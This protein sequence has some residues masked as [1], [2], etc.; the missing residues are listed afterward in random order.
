MKGGLQLEGHETFGNVR[1]LMRDGEPWFVARDVYEILDLGNS[2]QATSTLDDDEKDVI[3]LDTLGGKQDMAIISESGLY[4]L[5]FHSRKPEAKAFARWVRQVVLPSIR[6]TGGYGLAQSASSKRERERD[7]HARLARPEDRVL[8]AQPAALKACGLA[9]L[10]AS[11]I[12]T[13]IRSR[14]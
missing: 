13:V 5:I 2:R 9:G 6:K 8:R 4:A 7:P 10:D 12:W 11:H 3:I 14:I 1:V